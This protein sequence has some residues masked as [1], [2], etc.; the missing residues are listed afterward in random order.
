MTD[1]S[2]LPYRPCVGVM[3]LNAQDHVFVGRRANRKGASEGSG[4]WWQMPQ[5]GMDE[6]ETPE[7]A[8][9]RELKEETG[10]HSARFIAQTKDWLVYDLPPELIGVAWNGRYR[11]QKQMW[12]AARFEGEQ[13]EIDLGPPPGHHAE[14]D[15]WAWVP[16]SEL[17]DLVVPF[18][19][20]VYAQVVAEFEPLLERR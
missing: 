8:A 5:G 1:A 13:S 18:K 2:R 14:F 7:T 6:G 20:E 12:F 9:R 19:R 11:G 3:L 15:A 17:P 16:V 4:N 10:V